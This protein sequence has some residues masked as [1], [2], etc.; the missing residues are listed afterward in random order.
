[1]NK[2]L[3][4]RK[5]VNGVMLTLTGVCT[6]ATVSV[7]FVILGCLLYQGGRSLS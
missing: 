7:L 1:M 4:W 3:L 5:I 6:F 2:R